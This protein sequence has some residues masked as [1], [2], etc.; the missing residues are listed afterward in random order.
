MNPWGS[1]DWAHLELRVPGGSKN[2]VVSSATWWPG[3]ERTPGKCSSDYVCFG[4]PQ[5][6]G[7]PC[8]LIPEPQQL[9]LFFGGK[10][11]PPEKASHHFGLQFS[12][13]YSDRVGEGY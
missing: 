13:L 7:I 10:A 2:A 1:G 12:H 5:A 6:R 9:P 4:F 8:H 3:W 11:L